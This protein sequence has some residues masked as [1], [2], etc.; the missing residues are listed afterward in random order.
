MFSA[1]DNCGQ[2]RSADCGVCT[3]TDVC[4]ANVCTAPVCGAT[5]QGSPGTTVASLQVTGRQTALAGASTTGQSVLYLQTPVGAV[6]GAFSLFVADEAVAN[7]PPYVIQSLANVQAVIAGFSK[8]EETLA[9]SPDGLSIIGASS[10]GRTIVQSKRSA[11]GALDFATA[12]QGDF[13]AIDAALPASPATTQWPVLSA[14]GLAFYYHVAGA[15]V[16]AMNGEYEALRT[17]TTVPFPAGTLM[18]AAVQAFGGI[19]GMSSDRMTAFVAMGFGTQVMTRSSLAQPFATPA[20]GP[21]AAYRV[22]PI[23]GCTAI[24]TCEPG[25]CQNEAICTWTN[26]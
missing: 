2:P 13:A 24:G 22:M 18:P 5:F 8:T 17:S 20:T 14:D 15:T 25:G 10:D 11:I 23:E 21:G 1:M 4:D 12:A 26:H 19:S 7:I 16:T 3:G 9:I 6:C